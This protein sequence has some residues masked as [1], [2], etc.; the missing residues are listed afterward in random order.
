MR[1]AETLCPA[2]MVVGVE[3][4]LIPN[5]APVT[6][7]TDT[8]K[9]V[10]PVFERETLLVPVDPTLTV[11]KFTACELKEICGCM[12]TAVAERFNTTGL[13]VGSP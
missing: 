6:L 2:L 4:P 7:T 9:S 1:L 12:V 5:S 11:P 3:I 8:V 13:L 10:A